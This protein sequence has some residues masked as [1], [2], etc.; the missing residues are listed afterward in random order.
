MSLLPLVLFT[1]LATPG[2]FTAA[3]GLHVQTTGA[4]SFAVPYRGLSGP[5]D[6]WC[7]AGDYTIRAL[8]QP[9]AT[10]IFRTSPL[11]R[12]SGEGMEFSLNATASVGKTGLALLGADTDGVSAALAQ[13]LCSSIHSD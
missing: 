8:G 11:P 4:E 3:N 10:P 2:A 13:S 1:A 6:F 12:R 9:A 5:T 7:A